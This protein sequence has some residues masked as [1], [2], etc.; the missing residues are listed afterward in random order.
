[1]LYFTFISAPP[2]LNV[3]PLQILHILILNHIQEKPG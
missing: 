3:G 2:F 1:M